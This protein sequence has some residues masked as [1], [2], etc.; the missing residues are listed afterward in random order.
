[1]EQTIDALKRELRWLRFYSVLSCLVFTALLVMGFDNKETSLSESI[2]KVKGL[3][4]VDKNGIERVVIGS[5]FPDPISMGKRVPRGGEA[6]DLMAGIM[7]HDAEGN[8]RGGYMTSGFYPNIFL[9]FD[10]ITGQQMMLLNEPF[11]GS[12]MM[13]NSGNGNS[14]MLSG[15]RDTI[16]QSIT[17][18]PKK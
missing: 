6:N 5:D 1:M 12:S 7:L 9:T 13:V 2:L 17:L 16:I 3:I 18:T 15:S 8:E 11:G 10:Q 4:V 14:Y